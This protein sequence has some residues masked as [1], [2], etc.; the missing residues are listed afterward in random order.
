MTAMDASRDNIDNVLS[1][2]AASLLRCPSC[3]G[4]LRRLDLA[5]ACASCSTSFPIARGVPILLE[6][7]KSSFRL[8]H[9]PTAQRQAAARRSWLNV[10]KRRG[11]TIE[12]NLT[13]RKSILAFRDKLLAINPR[14]TVLNIGGKHPG[15][16]SVLVASDPAVDCIELHVAL[17]PRTNLIADPHS[18]PLP[19]E[20]VDAVI[21]DAVLE[22]MIDPVMVANELFRVLK[23]DGLLYSDSPFMVP[24]HGG[25]YDFMRFSQLAHRRLFRNFS[26]IASCV[27]GGPGSA[28]ALSIQAFL[29]SF[30]RSANARAVV[31][32]FCRLAL[33]WLKYFDRL[34]VDRPGS[35]D[36]ALGTIFVGQKSAEVL[37]DRELTRQYH[38]MSPRWASQFDSD[39][40]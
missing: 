26:Q 10:I 28:L 27:S 32:G 25:Q 24:V 31:K 40:P 16:F 22:H 12:V 11:P 37:S 19:D 9:I 3:M 1:E 8:P 14:P 20:S 39:R 2:R 33:F 30:V 35:L 29:L 5:L 6:V 15:S 18:L 34:L 17:A 23:K 7:A 21:I 38:G 13:G 4:T 36:A